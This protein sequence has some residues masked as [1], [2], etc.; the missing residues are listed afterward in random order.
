M[1]KINKIW[2]VKL[3]L[4]V[5]IVYNLYDWDEVSSSGTWKW[6]HDRDILFT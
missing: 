3:I 2:I 5:K 1:W 4:R 6:N